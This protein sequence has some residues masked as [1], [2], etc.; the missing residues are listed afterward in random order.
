MVSCL[1]T[2][3]V[4]AATGYSSLLVF[5]L[6]ILSLLTWLPY[7]TAFTACTQRVITFNSRR[8]SLANKSE[9]KL[10]SLPRTFAI[11]LHVTT[12]RYIRGLNS[13]HFLRTSTATWMGRDSRLLCWLYCE[14]TPV[15][16]HVRYVSYVL[17]CSPGL[18]AGFAVILLTVRMHVRCITFW[19]CCDPVPSACLTIHHSCFQSLACHSGQI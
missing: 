2:H 16:L 14:P 9:Q 18:L 13:R 3:G 7:S 17:E 4:W 1:L 8:F 11:Q 5:C 10:R 19:L 12:C 15:P 6:C